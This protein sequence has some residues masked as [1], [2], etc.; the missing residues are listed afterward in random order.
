MS[1]NI[2]GISSGPSD[3]Q[4]LVAEQQARAVQ[5][6]YEVYEGLPATANGRDAVL[7]AVNRSFSK[8]IQKEYGTSAQNLVDDLSQAQQTISLS[9][10]I[11]IQQALI[12][13]T[14]LASLPVCLKHKQSLVVNGIP[15]ARLKKNYSK[16][17][18]QM[19]FFQ[20]KSLR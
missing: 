15:L 4:I 10:D 2:G 3:Q 1:S 14:L 20:R 7:D 13:Q 11:L 18:I 17:Y 19:S 5:H 9:E 12:D 8:I 16:N 6:L